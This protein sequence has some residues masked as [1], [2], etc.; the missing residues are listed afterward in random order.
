MFSSVLKEVEK[1]V[2]VEATPVDWRLNPGRELRRSPRESI[3]CTPLVGW[4]ACT[5]PDASP[6]LEC[7][8]PYSPP[9]PTPTLVGITV[10][11]NHFTLDFQEVENS[12]SKELFSETHFS[13][14]QRKCLGLL[15]FFSIFLM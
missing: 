9:T 11:D 3:C 7:D 2:F 15:Y 13:R 12:V 1:C 4:G 6:V 8:G 14:M 5:A 10:E